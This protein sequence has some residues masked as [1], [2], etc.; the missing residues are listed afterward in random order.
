MEPVSGL[1]SLVYDVNA[2][3]VE[4][5]VERF[6]G[7]EF[8]CF[9]DER[10]ELFHFRKARLQRGRPTGPFNTIEEFT[11]PAHLLTLENCYNISGISVDR[12]K[13]Y[14]HQGRCAAIKKVWKY[15]NRIRKGY[16]ID[17]RDLRELMARQAIEKHYGRIQWDRSADETLK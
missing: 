7:A 3:G 12:L 13:Y 9:R 1:S 15:G 17:I 16:L 4:T 2:V 14:I 6:C 10:G 5:W 8:Q 11:R